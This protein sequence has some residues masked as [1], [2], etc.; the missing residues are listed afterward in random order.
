M[1]HCSPPLDFVVAP[2]SELESIQNE[3]DMTD[4]HSAPDEVAASHLVVRHNI[5]LGEQLRALST[6]NAE[7]LKRLQDVG[8]QVREKEDTIRKCKA[9]LVQHETA[10]DK[11]S[12]PVGMDIRHLTCAC[13]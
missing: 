4:L 1:E 12:P 6:E 11:A 5:A 2:T 13:T 3:V 9:L 7:L 10:N 8:D